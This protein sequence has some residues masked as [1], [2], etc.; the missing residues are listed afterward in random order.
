MSAA[1]GRPGG[2]AHGGDALIPLPPPNPLGCK[3]VL[4][5]A[6][7]TSQQYWVF[8]DAFDLQLWLA[9]VATCILVGVVVWA[10]DRWA[11]IRLPARGR[12]E[13]PDLETRV[14]TALGRPMQ[15]GAV[16]GGGPL[17]GGS[18]CCGQCMTWHAPASSSPVVCP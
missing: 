6:D 15:V 16:W 9:I 3:Q 2:A 7:D 5:L 13:V 14:W 10:A 4:V 1:A 11:W 12:P 18:S 8:L 17:G